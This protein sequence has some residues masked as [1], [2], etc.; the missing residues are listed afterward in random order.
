MN[1]RTCVHACNTVEKNFQSSKLLK[2]ERSEA[3][4]EDHPYNVKF[5]TRKESVSNAGRKLLIRDKILNL[6]VK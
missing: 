6:I 1:G 5:R 4:D 3:F 2:D